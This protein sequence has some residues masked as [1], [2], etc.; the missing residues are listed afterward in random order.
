VK[1]GVDSLNE[2]YEF[3]LGQN[4][5]LTGAARVSRTLQVRWV[6][7]AQGKTYRHSDTCRAALI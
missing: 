4:V 3:G 6:S 5:C 7:K 2:F 1:R